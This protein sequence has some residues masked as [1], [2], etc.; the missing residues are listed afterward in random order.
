MEI[1]VDVVGLRQNMLGKKS[2]LI[3]R[4]QPHAAFGAAHGVRTIADETERCAFEYPGNCRVRTDRN[5]AIEN[6]D[7][8]LKILGQVR[9][10]L[11]KDSQGHSVMAV[12][13]DSR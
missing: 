13:S 6:A 5:C 1:A 4:R 8:L 12:I 7:R 9:L 11:A 3:E 10:H 2:M